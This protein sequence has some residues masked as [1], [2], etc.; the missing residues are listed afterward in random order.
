MLGAGAEHSRRG[1][2]AVDEKN[3]LARERLRIGYAELLTE[4]EKFCCERLLVL[5]R[6]FP[7]GMM[8]FGIVERSVKERAASVTGLRGAFRECA[9][10]FT[11]LFT[12]IS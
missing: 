12:R 11:E 10:N 2:S 3:E 1:L 4:T 5:H 8:G 9:K 6:N 7:A